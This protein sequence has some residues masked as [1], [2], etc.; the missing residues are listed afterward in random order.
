MGYGGGLALAYFS[1]SFAERAEASR[2][3]GEPVDPTRHQSDR[4]GD[5]RPR[6]A[7]GPLVRAHM[8]FWD[9][10][11]WRYIGRLRQGRAAARLLQCLGRNRAPTSSRP[12]TIIQQILRRI[13]IGQ[14]VRRRALHL[15]ATTEVALRSTV[16]ARRDVPERGLDTAIGRL[17]RRGSTTTRATTSS[18]PI[19]ARSSRSRWRSRAG[20]FGSDTHPRSRTRHVLFHLVS[21]PATP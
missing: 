13:G 12:P 10:D 16:R 5:R 11:R 20:S 14:V 1:Q 4:D 19:A 18:R 8:G 3:A 21:R 17:G 2:A 9:H 15:H 7:R 6:T